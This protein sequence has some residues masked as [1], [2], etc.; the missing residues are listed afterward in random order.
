MTKNIATIIAAINNYIFNALLSGS[1]LTYVTLTD[2]INNTL[3]FYCN[4]S[5]KL[6]N[7]IDTNLVFKYST[8]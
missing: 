2:K 4:N 1:F 3:G 7:N 6:Q 8:N 5:V